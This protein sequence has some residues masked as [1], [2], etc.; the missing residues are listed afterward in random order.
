MN[1]ILTPLPILEQHDSS[2]SSSS[3]CEDEKK[4]EI[5]T[6]DVFEINTVSSQHRS[7]QI[8]QQPI[9]SRFSRNSSSI[10][11]KSYDSKQISL[12]DS[13]LACVQVK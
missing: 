8:L 2:S 6:L 3:I 1:E 10:S 13:E 4:D 9:M 7:I 5:D 12:F 11:N